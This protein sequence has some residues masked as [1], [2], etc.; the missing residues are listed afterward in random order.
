MFFFSENQGNDIKPHSIEGAYYAILQNDLHL[1]QA[2]F[3]S[4]DSPRAR[5]GK[6]LID[7]LLGY[8]EN[9]PTYF[10]IRNFLEI[11]LDFLIKNEKID[12]I[13]MILGS[14]DLLI[15]INQETYKYVARVMFENHLYNVAQK[16][17]E[18]SLNL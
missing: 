14:L 12:Y 9:Y 1:A 10:E 17:L 4:L 2:R 13:E 7:I 3:E 8:V 6:C 18:K 15:N 16:Y 11:D 5:W